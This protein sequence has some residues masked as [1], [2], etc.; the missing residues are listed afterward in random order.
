MSYCRRHSAA[1]A[2]APTINLFRKSV[3]KFSRLKKRF[4]ACVRKS[5]NFFHTSANP[6]CLGRVVNSFASLFP[7]VNLINA[8]KSYITTV[9]SQWP[10]N[11]LYF[12]Y[13]KL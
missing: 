4:D 10:E 5:D 1:A 2:A 3:E 7:V 13:S 6:S 8:Q 11:Y 9:D 12:D